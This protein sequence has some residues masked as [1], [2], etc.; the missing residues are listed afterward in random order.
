MAPRSLL[1]RRAVRLALLFAACV[2]TRAAE[3][4]SCASPD[5][6]TPQ[7]DIEGLSAQA[8]APPTWLP[9]PPSRRSPYQITHLATFSDSP[10]PSVTRIV[11]TA[12]D[13]A[14]RAY[15]KELMGAAGLAVRCVTHAPPP[16]RQPGCVHACALACACAETARLA[17]RSRACQSLRRRRTSTSARLPPCQWTR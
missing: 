2:A 10:A 8:R 11:Y 1:G 5:L 3:P 7:V 13:L 12:N 9:P 14:A 17:R 4:E 16:P 15:V 6:P